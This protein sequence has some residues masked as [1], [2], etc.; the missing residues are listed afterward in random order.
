MIETAILV[1]TLYAGRYVGRESYC[2]MAYGDGIALPVETHGQ[3]WQ[4]NDLV[5]IRFEDGVTLMARAYDAGPFGYNCVM[6]SDGCLPIVAD[7]PANMWQH[8]DAISAKVSFIVNIT[9][10]ARRATNY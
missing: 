9:D 8:G 1:A 10:Q 2:N 4:C 6:G 5:Y 7:I 3:E